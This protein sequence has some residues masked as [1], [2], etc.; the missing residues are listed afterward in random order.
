MPV[1]VRHHEAMEVN[2]V[3]YAGSVTMDE[4]AALA[5]FN[6]ANPAWVTYD[7]LSVVLP[8]AD[9][10]SINLAELDALS[11]RYRAIYEP[12]NFLIMRRSAWLCLSAAAEKHVRHW[13]GDPRE[14]REN[15]ASDVRLFESYEA[16]GEWLL[17][18]PGE[19]EALTAC[20]GFHEVA[21]FGSAPARAP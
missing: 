20:E 12:L 3:D 9:F 6:A 11:A 16:A 19:I 10:R 15:M 8:G 18:R 4:L 21:R 2:R 1:V 13:V 7:C 5:A 17:L 14:R